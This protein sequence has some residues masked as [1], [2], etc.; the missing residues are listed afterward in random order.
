MDSNIYKVEFSRVNHSIFHKFSVLENS[1]ES[2]LEVLEKSLNF[3]QTCLYEPCV[4]VLCF[5]LVLPLLGM[6]YL[7][8]GFPGLVNPF[9]PNELS[10]IYQ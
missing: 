10:Y 7:S 8:M 2:L 3:A 1:R 4:S 6:W 5:F 9:K